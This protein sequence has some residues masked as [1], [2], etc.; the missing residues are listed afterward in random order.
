MR[1]KTNIAEVELEEYRKKTKP[2]QHDEQPVTSITESVDAQN[3]IDTSEV[4]IPLGE[5]SGEQ[6]DWNPGVKGSPHLFM[7]GIPGQGKSWTI[8]R[9]VSELAQ[10]KCSL[11]CPGLS[12]T[13]CRVTSYFDKSNPTKCA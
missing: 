12:W 9:I 10:A 13:I 6:V 5:A 7:L 11:T 4:V 1:C 2:L 8:T 3:Q